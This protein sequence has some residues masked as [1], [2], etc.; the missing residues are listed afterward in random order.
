MSDTYAPPVATSWLPRDL[1]DVLSGQWEPDQ[2]TV[3]TRNDGTGMFYRGRSH[4]VSGESESL[5]TWFALAAAQDELGKAEHVV[6]VD[7][8][9]HEGPV[10]GRLLAM[11]ASP[12]RIASHFHY[13]RPEA[14]LEENLGHADLEVLLGDTRPSLAIIDGVT[15]GMA[16]HGLNPLDNR[17]A[18]TFG[19]KLPRRLTAAG[20]ACV[21]LDHL[22]KS[23]ENRGRYA[24]GAVH[25][26]NALDG[27]AYVLENRSAAGVGLIG[28]STV[29][30]A[31]DRPGQLRKHALPSSGMHWFADLL[32][33]STHPGHVETTVVA[34]DPGP[35]HGE[36]HR[37]THLMTKISSILAEKGPLSQRQIL[38]LMGGRREYA[39]KALTLLTVDG[40]V[41]EKTPHQLIKPFPDEADQ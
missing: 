12:D 31:K 39:I 16:L 5:K 3:G 40:H 23:S 11:G 36:D 9:D 10:V 8:E 29:K 6:F 30:I 21:S 18:A 28:K 2:P 38:A 22:T 7:F 35:A 1:T 41:T 13:I 4:T 14:P 17:D 26:L 20:A 33:D 15:E 27:A 34:P 37:P 19:R 25:K 24:L 32:L